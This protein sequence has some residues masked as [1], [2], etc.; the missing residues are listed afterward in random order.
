MNVICD[1]AH[2]MADVTH[3]RGRGNVLHLYCDFIC[4]MCVYGYYDYVYR[5]A[6]II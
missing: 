4:D 3:S 2:H 5:Y 1:T 6:Q